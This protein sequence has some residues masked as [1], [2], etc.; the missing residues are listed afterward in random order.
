MHRI[1]FRSNLNGDLDTK[2]KCWTVP[3]TKTK[4]TTLQKIT[5]HLSKYSVKFDLDNDSITVLQ[6]VQT[7]QNDYKKNLQ[8]GNKAK[9][10]INIS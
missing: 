6:K 3:I 10:N 5:D 9:K 1:F 4:Y 2:K 8:K 7:A